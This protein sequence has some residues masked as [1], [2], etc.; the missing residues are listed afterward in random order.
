VDHAIQGGRLYAKRLATGAS[1]VWGTSPLPACFAGETRIETRNSVYLLRDGICR[2]VIR[3]ELA[4]TTGT[5]KT[6]LVGMRLMGWVES[7][8]SSSVMQLDWYRGM[9]GVLWRPR[10]GSE[11]HSVVALTSPTLAFVM[12]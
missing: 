11:R 6:H 7:D 4:S 8:E 10:H 9:R 12:S 2:A 5:H 1:H 3:P